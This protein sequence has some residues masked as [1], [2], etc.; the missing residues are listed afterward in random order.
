[1]NIWDNFF[2]VDADFCSPGVCYICDEDAEK[3]AGEE[4]IALMMAAAVEASA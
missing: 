4:F 3:E 1:M 2:S